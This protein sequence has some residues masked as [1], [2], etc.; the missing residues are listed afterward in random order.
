LFKGIN[1]MLFV[2]YFVHF[3][4]D[5][6][7][8]LITAAVYVMSERFM[9][10]CTV[11]K[12]YFTY[13]CYVNFCLYFPYLLSSWGEIACERSVYDAGERVL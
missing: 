1:G 11:K 7:K 5:W 13:K 6:A 4:C 9:H 10:F 2:L 12:I 8:I 3:V